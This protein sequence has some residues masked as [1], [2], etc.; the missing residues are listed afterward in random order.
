MLQGSRAISDR[1]KLAQKSSGG[2]RSPALQFQ[3]GK[4]NRAVQGWKGGDDGGKGDVN[5]IPG[6][7]LV[8]IICIAFQRIL[9][10][11]LDSIEGRLTREIGGNPL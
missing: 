11:P 10:T 6:V 1:A 3:Y 2:E 8:I 9:F 7:K 5:D 4:F